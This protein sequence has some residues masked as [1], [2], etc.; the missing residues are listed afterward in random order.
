MTMYCLSTVRGNYRHLRC[1]RRAVSA[2]RF[3]DYV[4]NRKRH[5]R[6]TNRLVLLSA[7]SDIRAKVAFVQCCFTSTETVRTI[8]DG[9]PRTFTSTFTDTAPE[10]WNET[11]FRHLTGYSINTWP[12]TVMTELRS[13]VKVEVYVLGSPSLICLTVSV[14]V[15][16]R[17]RRRKVMMTLQHRLLT[18]TEA[19]HYSFYVYM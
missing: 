1:R 19:V 18:G 17:G 14:D 12:E 7:G 4:I 3:A 15:K 2:Q 5:C 13:C 6:L 8:R 10:L 16:H 11:C 9:E